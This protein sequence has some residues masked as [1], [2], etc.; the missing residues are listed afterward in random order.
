[1]ARDLD[2]VRRRSEDLVRRNLGSRAARERARNRVQHGARSVVRRLR[3]AALTFV[4]LIVLVIAG[5]ATGT[6]GLFSTPLALIAAFV[7]SLVVLFW[8]SRSRPIQPPRT[9]DGGVATRLDALAVQAEDY[10]LDRS[11]ALPHHAGPALDRIVDRLRDLEPA[12]ATV[13]ADATLGGE[14][15]RLI[16][17]HLPGLV[18]TYLGL[19]PSE[20]TFESENS[21]RL[22]ESLGIVADELDH[23]C[24]R[25]GEERRTGF[26]TER[27]FLET[28]YRDGDRF[29]LDRPER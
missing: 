21:H 9:I 7:I 28:R 6:L 10:L 26:E 20:R 27:R 23:L 2:Q 22:S 15:Q 17:Q 14:A 25:V 3:N 5:L 8:P 16:G 18:D 19:P 11:R 12:L 1:M 4:G 24:E 29:S 13:P